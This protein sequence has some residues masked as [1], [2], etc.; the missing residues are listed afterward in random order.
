MLPEVTMAD[1][2]SQIRDPVEVLAEE[3]LERRRRGEVPSLKEYTERYPHLAEEIHE[4][5]PA[6]VMMDEIDPHSEELGQDRGGT[7][8]LYGRPKFRQLGDFRILREIGQGGMGVV[9][10]ALQESLGRHVALKVLLPVF[11]RRE[12]FRERFQREARAAAGL[13]HTNIV[14]IFGVGEDQ[15]VLYY[16]M[17][18]IQGQAL[19]AVLEDVKRMRGLAITEDPADQPTLAQSASRAARGLLT[20]QFRSAGA[21]PSLDPTPD[22]LSR[23]L[24]RCERVEPPTPAVHSEQARRLNRQGERKVKGETCPAQVVAIPGDS[25]THSN[26][27]NQPEARY[28]RSVAWLG[29]QAAEGLAHAHAQGILHRDIK[30]SNMLLDAQGTLWI[31]DFGLAKAEGA[32]DL[33]HTGE[34]VGTLRYMPPERFE[35][36]GD[37]RSDVYGLG[38]TLYEM[39]TLSPAFSGNDRAGLMGQITNDT[40]PA[41]SRLVPHLP[42]DLETI[43]Q[44]AM[45]REPAGRY[46]TA[47]SLADD[48]RRFVENRPIKARRSSVVERTYRWCRRNPAL[49]VLVSTVFLLLLCLTI[50]SVVVA[51]RLSLQSA[52]L[53]ASEADRTEKL[54][55]TY[56][57]SV[58]QAY[59]NRF[60]HRAGQRFE[61]LKVIREA[62]KLLSERQMPSERFDELRSLA[63]GAL[64]LP[65]VRSL[66]SWNKV[67]FGNEQWDADDQLRLYA[68]REI[69]NVVTVRTLDTNQVIAQVQGKNYL[70]FSPG[71]R[72]LLSYDHDSLRV[73][74]LS[75]TPPRLLPDVEMRTFAFHPDGRH[76]LVAKRDGSIW[77]DDLDSQGR[78][79]AFI[80][81]LDPPVDYCA[82]DAT[83]G[84]LAVIRGGKPEVREGQT[85][86]I[87][88]SLPEPGVGGVPAW[89]PSGAYIALMASKTSRD[90]GVWDI[91]SMTRVSVL[92]GVRG[93]N[94]RVG[95]TPDGGKLLSATDEGVHLWDWRTERQLLQILGSSNLRINSAGEFL[96][97]SDEQFTL[98]ALESG[99]EF[100]SLVKQSS[101]DEQSAY[102]Q[103]IIHPNG[104][105][106]G[107]NMHRETQNELRLFDL[108]AGEELAVVP[109]TRWNNAFL[110]DGAIV[111]N[112]DG[113]LLRWPLHEVDARHWQLGAPQLLFPASFV[114]MAADRVGSVIGQATGDGILLVRPGK[115]AAHL[116]P[117]EGAQHISISPDGNYAVSGINDGEEG[118]KLWNLTTRRLITTFPVGRMCGGSFSPDGRWLEV[119][120][121]RGCRIVKA[122]TW[123]T[124][125]PIDHWHSGAFSPDG[126]LFAAENG[127]G[128]I[129]LLNPATGKELARLEDPNHASSWLVFSA[130]GTRLIGSS[131][132]DRCVHVWDLRLI[133]RQLAE[134]GLDW[135]APPY[136]VAETQELQPLHV[137]V[138]SGNATLDPRM[139]IGL[140]TLRLVLNPFDFEA[141]FQRG[142]AH[143]RQDDTEQ[144]ISD[145]SMA[146]AFMPPAHTNRGEAL[147]RLSGNYRRSNDRSKAEADLQEIAKRDLPLPETLALLAAQQFNE[148]ARQFVT[149]RDSERHP[150]DAL[151]LIRKAIRLTPDEWMLFNTQG[152]VYYRLGDYAESVNW[153]RRS[154]D[155]NNAERAALDLFFLAM[156][157][158]KLGARETAID[159]YDRA[160]R[161]MQEHGDG[162]Q[163]SVTAELNSIQREADETLN[164]SPPVAKSAAR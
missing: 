6:L 69:G 36:K 111:T 131:D 132:V 130:D 45:A 17:Q 116:G 16:A 71:G 32:N 47:H 161:W 98:V 114:D 85:G 119:A 122:P 60:S 105:L 76:L 91:R 89:H 113:G 106:L 66:R 70:Q 153:L 62:A 4:V 46:S 126:T 154:L 127:P 84:R 160:R 123:E 99:K 93:A 143:G 82:F 117:H 96:V 77:R 2:P 146:L 14:P 135:D 74:D 159:W 8:D 97:E 59:V 13:H 78:E 7:T 94:S 128:L 156:C 23:E 48:L 42:R 158:A 148:L 34:F 140:C 61:T 24:A 18:F 43:V 151:L 35:G 108:E 145:Y 107:V 22:H 103:P 136:P 141:Y 125:F 10:E 25:G 164:L 63:I 139:T 37:A 58:A 80:I 26:L 68:R 157:H 134:M 144:A 75:K 29:V 39:L 137:T 110:A 162:L 102:G 72:F 104:R 87:L 1:Q 19:D 83:G 112:G 44:K 28:Y 49:A 155:Q 9:Y 56:Q 88:L 11:S 142:K 73:W 38:V 138:N 150:D 92:K 53:A 115:P 12:H 15:G 3:F 109:G 152:I 133:R 51:V 65:D 20:G 149:G 163:P 40:P 121:S 101:L 120:G 118:V 41:P 95:F 27:S 33:T 5:F 79:P 67:P 124:T 50:G 90:V 81:K 147:L 54:Y 31:T 52:A 129:R 57:A 55:Q 21:P 86:R 30:P 100:R 64:I